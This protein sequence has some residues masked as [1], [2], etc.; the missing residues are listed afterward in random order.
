MDPK[1]QI[2]VT[3]GATQAIFVVMNCLL[4]PGDEVLLPTPLFVAYK[5]SAMLAGGTCVEVPTLEDEGFALDLEKLEKHCSKKAKLLVLNSP[6]NPTGSVLKKDAIE[7]AC[8]FAARH[9]LYIISDEIYE[10]Y[11]YRW[12]E[13]FQPRVNR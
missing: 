3:S 1:S 8:E 2:I 4:N 10:K 7:K 9:N 12:S 6:C 13:T 5:N 11:L